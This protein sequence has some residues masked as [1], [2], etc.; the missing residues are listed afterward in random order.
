[1]KVFELATIPARERRAVLR[2]LLLAWSPFDQSGYAVVLKGER[3]LAW[4]WDAQQLRDGFAA[5]QAK[6]MGCMPEGLLRR[7]PVADGI[8]WV[9]C[10][11][12]VELQVWRGGLPLASRWW[13]QR[14]GHDE[15]LAFLRGLG[16]LA[17]GL[18]ELPDE[19][20]WQARPWAEPLGVDALTST[21]S[22][23]EQLATGVAML[24]LVALSAAQAR[25]LV[26]AHQEHQAVSAELEQARLAA[27][28]VLVARDRALA[29]ARELDALARQLTAAQPLE[30][31]QHLAELLPARGIVLKEFELNGSKLRVGFELP[32]AM[33]RSA[34]VRD[35]QAG[36]WFT[37]VSEVRE[38]AG[39]NWVTFE[40]TLSSASPPPG[41]PA[42]AREAGTTGKPS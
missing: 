27:A 18:A 40:M 4:A 19:P 38:T 32:P 21:F 20:S 22:R 41:K 6:E 37:G 26:T 9:R 14:P 39:R 31:M 7:P 2:N 30:V 10:L 24:G 36:A 5:V 15:H 28:P 34:M 13:A 12:G 35:L 8:R 23:L 25:E 3:A 11:D 42:A 17:D 29:Q 16:E 33:A 1:V